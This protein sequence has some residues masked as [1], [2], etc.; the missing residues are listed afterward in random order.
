M[1]EVFASSAVIVVVIAVAFLLLAVR[2]VALGYPPPRISTR[3]LSAKEQAIVASCADALFPAG[4]PI[5]ISG[6]EAGVVEYVALFVERTPRATRALMRMLFR[7]VEHST[8]L[9]GP[10]RARFSRLS[11]AERIA[12]LSAMAESRFYFRRVSFL[13]LRTMLSMGYLANEEVA[14]AIGCTFC[15]APF[16]RRARGAGEPGAAP[17]GPLAREEIA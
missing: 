6:T 15:V 12:A 8:W 10:R 7:F 1:S 13:S 4:G 9:F 2:G 16:E 17:A 3:V 11:V 14:R 5:P